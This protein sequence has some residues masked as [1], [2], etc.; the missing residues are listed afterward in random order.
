MKI[1]IPYRGKLPVAALAV[2]LRR[3]NAYGMVP[4]S[5]KTKNYGDV[6]HLNIEAVNIKYPLLLIP[7]AV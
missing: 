7:L 3:I 6:S 1:C 4:I 2:A 5:L